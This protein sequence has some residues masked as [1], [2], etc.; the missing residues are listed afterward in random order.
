MEYLNNMSKQTKESR[1]L[2]MGWCKLHRLA[3]LNSQ[4]SKPPEKLIT[5]KEKTNDSDFGPPFIAQRLEIL[6]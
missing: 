5:Y 2:F 4:F 6:L 3:I 1:A